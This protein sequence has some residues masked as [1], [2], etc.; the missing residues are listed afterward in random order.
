MPS[1]PSRNKA[2]EIASKNYAKAEVLSDF[3]RFLCFVPNTLIEFQYQIWIVVNSS[4][5]LLSSFSSSLHLSCPNI[6]INICVKT[7]TVTKI[8]KRIMY[9]M[10]CGVF[11]AKAVFNGNSRQIYKK[12]YFTIYAKQQNFNTTGKFQYLVLSNFL[13]IL[14]KCLVL[15]EEWVIG[16][17]F[18]QF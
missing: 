11:L 13:Q 6:C 3:T 14:P 12:H 2:L 5:K 16:Y 7:L 8:F 1:L 18:V 9:E 4:E 15:E 10:V 17:N